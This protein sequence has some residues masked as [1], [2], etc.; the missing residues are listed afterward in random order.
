MLEYRGVARYGQW[1]KTRGEDPRFGESGNRKIRNR[2]IPEFPIR[3]LK[4]DDPMETG[5]SDRPSL[6]FGLE[7]QESC[8]F[9]FSDFPIPRPSAVSRPEF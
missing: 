6:N 4:M 2:T 8:D 5:P 1:E 3:N 9:E 7:I